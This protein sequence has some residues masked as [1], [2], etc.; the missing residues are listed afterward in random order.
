MSFNASTQQTPRRLG[1][2]ITD[3]GVHGFKFHP[4]LQGFF[5]NDRLAYPLY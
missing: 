3:Y 5:A 4:T 1:T 2:L